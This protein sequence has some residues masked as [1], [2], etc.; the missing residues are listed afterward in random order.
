MIEDT[1][2]FISKLDLLEMF[3]TCISVRQVGSIGG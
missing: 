2:L 3:E 1:S